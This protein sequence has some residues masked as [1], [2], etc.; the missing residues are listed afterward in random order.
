MN[1]GEDISLE[2]PG[3][4]SQQSLT[5][6]AKCSLLTRRWHKAKLR[7]VDIPV[8]YSNNSFYHLY[9]KIFINQCYTWRLHTMD[10]IVNMM[11]NMMSVQW[12]V[13]KWVIQF[14]ACPLI[15]ILDLPNPSARGDWILMGWILCV[16]NGWNSV[17][18]LLWSF[19][20]SLNHFN[21]SIE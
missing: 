9:F 3:L 18:R 15:G 17:R 2:W 16:E 20:V 1:V 14:S 12:M 7:D 5:S 11:K 10:A 6:T 8:Y 13:V 21:L 19:T 4:H